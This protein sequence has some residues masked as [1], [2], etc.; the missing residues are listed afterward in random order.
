MSDKEFGIK[1]TKTDSG[2]KIEVNRNEEMVKAH[3]EVA[4][5]CREFASKARD[6][7]KEHFQ[8]HRDYH[9]AHHGCCDHEVKKEDVDIK[10]E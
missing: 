5:A 10:A 2:F 8:R 3:R 6:V 1:F 4:D 9:H 7:A